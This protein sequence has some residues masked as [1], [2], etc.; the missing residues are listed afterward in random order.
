MHEHHEARRDELKDRHG[1]VYSDIEHVKSELDALATELHNLTTHAVSL[2]A[3]FDRYGYSAHLRTKDENEE[4]TSLHSDTLSASE[5]HS[6]RSVEPLRF[7]RRP[8]V[9]QYF[10]KGLLWRSAKAGEVASFELF[11]DLVYV[12]VIDIIGE[13]AVEHPNG[14]SL[15][16]FVIVFSVGKVTRNEGPLHMTDTRTAWKIWS[17]LTMM[18]NYFEID[19]IVHRFMVIFYLACLFGFTTVGFHASAST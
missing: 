7:L 13:T 18:I 10:H 17:D 4:T 2:D 1:E 6:D 12:G 14:L 3:S 15:L 9:R 5:R 19:D 11:A 8:V 16:H